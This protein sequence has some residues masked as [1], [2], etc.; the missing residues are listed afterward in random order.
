MCISISVNVHQYIYIYI[1]NIYIYIYIYIMNTPSS[2]IHRTTLQGFRYF[3]LFYFTLSLV[4]FKVLEKQLLRGTPLS[5]CFQGLQLLVFSS[6]FYNIS[7]AFHLSSFNN[8]SQKV[9]FRPLVNNYFCCKICFKDLNYFLK[10]LFKFSQNIC[11]SFSL[12]YIS[13]LYK[14]LDFQIILLPFG[15]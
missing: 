11:T 12:L 6:A 8:V 14:F 4:K 10:Q 13:K 9:F 5:S 7:Q 1:Y 3:T 2:Y 15:R